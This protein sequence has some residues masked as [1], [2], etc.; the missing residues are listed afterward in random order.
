MRRVR[1]VDPRELLGHGARELLD[2]P[3]ASMLVAVDL[4]P[5]ARV[6]ESEVGGRV[7]DRHRDARRGRR[8]EQLV[9][10]LRR[11]A[12][13]RAREH[14]PVRRRAQPLDRG[15][16]RHEELV[17]VG[18]RE[19]RERLRDR[20]AGLARRDDRAERKARMRVD[21]AQEFAGN[22]ARPAEHDRGISR[23]CG[24]HPAAFASRLPR[25]MLAWSKS[26]SSAEC[27]IALMAATFERSLMMS[28]PTWLSVAGPEITVG[29]MP[30]SSRSSFAPP[31]AP[32]GSF[33]HSTSEVIAPTMSLSRRIASTPYAPSSPSPS[34][35]TIASG[36][37]SA[38]S[39]SRLRVSAGAFFEVVAQM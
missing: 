7:D 29:S 22:V 12:V 15:V 21:Q 4:R 11:R 37:S 14:E 33:A 20:L 13:R 5:F 19:V 9:D 10:E 36:F 27:V 28:M 26:P 6:G 18:G 34:S 8:A 23:L 30:N 39:L 17:R 3:G 16:D 31:Q 2:Q 25:P 38:S 1:R 24:V 32:T 35:N